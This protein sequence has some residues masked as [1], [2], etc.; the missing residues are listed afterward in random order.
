MYYLILTEPAKN[1]P[2]NLYNLP[3]L[4]DCNISP[5][6]DR[7]KYTITANPTLASQALIVSNTKKKGVETTPSPRLVNGTPKT[8]TIET[9]SN[10]NKAIRKCSRCKKK[11]KKIIP[12]II[13]RT[14]AVDTINTQSRYSS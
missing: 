5:P 11:E 10:N 4:I 2:Y 14:K 12:T 1:L 6:N 8:N 7:T 13:I 3:T 9:S